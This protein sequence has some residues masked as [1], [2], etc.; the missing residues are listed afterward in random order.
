M[1][2]LNPALSCDWHAPTAVLRMADSFI[3]SPVMVLRLVSQCLELIAEELD[4]S[5]HIVNAGA[6]LLY[7]LF[8]FV[9][10][11]A[12]LRRPSTM[13]ALMKGLCDPR[14][15]KG[16]DM[17]ALASLEAAMYVE[18]GRAREKERE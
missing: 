2:G 8:Y 16:K 14:H 11:R 13:V 4:R 1:A 15:L 7:P 18:G 9:V 5:A 3:D 17:W 10:V 12:R 6:D